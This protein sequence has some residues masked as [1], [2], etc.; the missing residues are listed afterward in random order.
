MT[1]ARVDYAVPGLAEADVADTPLSQFS[2]WLAEAQ[3]AEV[4]EPNA[5]SLATCGPDGPQVRVV[6]AKDVDPY[7]VTFYTNL[8]S[9][10]A[11]DLAQDSRAAAVFAWLAQYRQVRVRGPVVPLGRQVAASYFATRPRG[12]QIGAWASPQSQVIAS[13]EDLVE[14]ITEAEQRF[15]EDVP[16]PLPERW[17]GYRI[18]PTVVEFWQGQ[19]SRLHDRIRF[20]SLQAEAR[21]DDASAWGLERLAP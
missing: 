8:D 5:M 17:G 9:V 3:A 16:V 14:R 21:L 7:G 13:R 12:A 6:L 18:K 4:P 10:K 20:E 15:P 19:P 1:R 11:Q 2:K